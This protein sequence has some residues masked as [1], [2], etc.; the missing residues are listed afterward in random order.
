MKL[1]LTIV[2]PTLNRTI[3]LKKLLNYYRKFK[4]SG[5]I[6]VLDSS[7]GEVKKKNKFLCSSCSELDIKYINIKGYPHEVIKKCINFAKSS[8]VVFS[9]DDDYFIVS[10]L[11][12]I[13][14]FLEKNKNI[15]TAC[16]EAVIFYELNNKM[17]ATYEYSSLNAR[18]E[19]TAFE[20]V[21]AN[22]KNYSVAHYSICRKNIFSLAFKNV[23]RVLCPSRSFNDER[24]AAMTLICLG[25]AE[26]I[27]IPYLIRKIGHGR[28]SLTEVSG[29]ESNKLRISLNYLIHT[30]LKE[31]KKIDRKMKKSYKKQLHSEY[32]KNFNT[33]INR[34]LAMTLFLKVLNFYKST[35]FFRLKEVFILNFLTKFLELFIFDKF[36]YSNIVKKKLYYKDLISAITYLKKN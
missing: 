4:F 36:Y 32:K 26:K 11:K 34:G 24:I 12:K 35:F 5:E 8:Y 27:K 1:D 17:V 18:L 19:K 33:N 23:N 20:R 14:F 13:I 16:A 21:L 15:A 28:T 29:L 30:L 9:G 22:M 2:V 3:F 31:I 10:A 25:R 6:L 7:E